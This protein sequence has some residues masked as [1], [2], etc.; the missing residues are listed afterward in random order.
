MR[1]RTCSLSDRLLPLATTV[2]NHL[3]LKSRHSL[4]VDLTRT[5]RCVTVLLMTLVYSVIVRR[6]RSPPSSTCCLVTDACPENCTRQRLVRFSSVL[7]S[8]TLAT[9]FS[10]S[11]PQFWNYL[12]TDLRQL[13]LSYS[14]HVRH[15]L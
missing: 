1:P 7:H 8:P 11:E 4:S 2:T 14:S 6:S 13:D 12:L 15:S 10:A 5:S 9:A 3:L